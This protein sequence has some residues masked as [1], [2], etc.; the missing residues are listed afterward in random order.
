VTIIPKLDGDLANGGKLYK[1]EC[2][3][4]H[5]ADGRGKLRF[6]MLVGQYTAYLQKQM[7]AYLKGERPHDAVDNEEEED[8]K[9]KA[10]TAVRKVGV[11]NRLTEKDLQDILAHITRL[12]DE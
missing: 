2:A 8:A 5:G 1:E 11:L 6:P 3:Y 7:D 4:C 10:K 9:P 12:Q